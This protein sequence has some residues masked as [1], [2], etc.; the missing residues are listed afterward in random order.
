MINIRTEVYQLENCFIGVDPNSC[1]P[2]VASRPERVFMSEFY[3]NTAKTSTSEIVKTFKSK[4]NIDFFEPGEVVKF[5]GIEITDD[6]VIYEAYSANYIFK[7]IL[8]GGWSD[9]KDR[10]KL[11]YHVKRVEKLPNM[12][13]TMITIYNFKN[14]K[15]F[16]DKVAALCSDYDWEYDETVVGFPITYCTQNGITAYYDYED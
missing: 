8:S 7:V 1:E 13:A 12:D 9:T 10:I 11:K 14:E 15:D 3:F 6:G 2:I 16:K 4:C 5:R